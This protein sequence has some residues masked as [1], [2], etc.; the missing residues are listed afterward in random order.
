MQL[1]GQIRLDPVE[2]PAG[3]NGGDLQL[4]SA[5]TR[6]LGILICDEQILDRLQARRGIVPVDLVPGSRVWG[7][8][9][10]VSNAPSL[11]N[12]I[13]GSALW[14]PGPAGADQQ[15]PGSP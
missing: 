8:A 15:R 4:A 12:P 13:S 14:A 6:E 2:L 7:P 5:V 11:P 1:A 3:D 10:G 9:S